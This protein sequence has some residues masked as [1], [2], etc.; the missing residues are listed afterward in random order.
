[1]DKILKMVYG[2]KTI[3]ADECK[4][5]AFG[6]HNGI[7][8]AVINHSG[9]YPCAYVEVTGTKYDESKEFNELESD[10]RLNYWTA[11]R[12][13]RNA[14]YS[15]GMSDVVH[16]GLTYSGNQFYGVYEPTADE[17]TTRWFVG[18][19]YCHCGDN[20][21][22]PHIECKCVGKKWTTEEII[23]ECKACIEALKIECLQ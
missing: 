14:A 8:Y 7:S 4:L 9:A 2:D 5:L 3:N 6:E 1:M 21:E 22:F 16:G 15:S 11:N 19:D 12:E 20:I 23:E 10:K 17:K 18:W 13:K